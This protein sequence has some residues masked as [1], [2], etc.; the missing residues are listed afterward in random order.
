MDVFLSDVA[1]K[2]GIILDFWGLVWVEARESVVNTWTEQ[3]KTL[4]ILV[5]V[6][7]GGG[8]STDKTARSD[9]SLVNGWNPVGY[10]RESNPRIRME[11]EGEQDQVW[12]YVDSVW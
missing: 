7:T 10:G 5:D 9:W 11:K 4:I 3:W 8:R 12:R 6:A 2:V 1:N